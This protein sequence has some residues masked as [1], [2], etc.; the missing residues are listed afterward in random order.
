MENG[1]LLIHS[2]TPSALFLVAPSWWN[3]LLLVQENECWKKQFFI[4]FCGG[5]EGGDFDIGVVEESHL[6]R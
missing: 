4:F 6:L 5:G 1:A 2:F 3:E